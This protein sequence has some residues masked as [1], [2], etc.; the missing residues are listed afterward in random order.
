MEQLLLRA[1][2]TDNPKDKGDHA[3]TDPTQ[4]EELLFRALATD[5]PVENEQSNKASPELTQ[6]ETRASA[7]KITTTPAR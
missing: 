2:T 6:M 3:K 4:V 1:L 7:H 5:P